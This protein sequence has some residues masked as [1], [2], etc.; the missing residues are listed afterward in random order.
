M[1][2]PHFCG[3]AP[4]AWWAEKRYGRP[5]TASRQLQSISLADVV[6]CFPGSVF[7]GKICSQRDL[8]A[9]KLAGTHPALCNDDSP[10]PRTT[11]EAL[12]DAASATRL[13]FWIPSSLLCTACD[14]TLSFFFD[15]SC[16]GTASPDSNGRNE[17]SSWV[18]MACGFSTENVLSVSP[19]VLQDG[20]RRPIM[21]SFAVGIFSDTHH[22]AIAHDGD[23]GIRGA[24]AMKTRKD[25]TA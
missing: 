13:S 1:W 8:K 9:A 17:L 12:L 6:P 22:V 14:T 24:T 18:S 10:S 2:Q 4:S 21:P 25:H 11:Y 15:R 3:I 23:D 7:R 19:L 20:H 5:G 16:Q